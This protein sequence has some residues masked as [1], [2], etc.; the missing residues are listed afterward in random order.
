M[1]HKP[2]VAISQIADWL[3]NRYDGE[4]MELAPISG[5][6]WSAAYTYRVGEAEFVLRFSDMADGFAI[7]AAA[8]QFTAP[9]LPIP[10][11]IEVGEA[12]GRH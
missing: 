9:D 4:V 12:L 2:K 8:M 11:V 5:G 7:D 3:A 1:T 6:F 10:E